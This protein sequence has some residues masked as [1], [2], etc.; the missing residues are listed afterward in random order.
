M[1]LYH[2]VHCPFC[3]RVRLALG[4]LQLAYDSNVVPY[5]DE[6]TPTKLTGKKMLPIMA[7]DDGTVMNESLDIINKLDSNNLLKNELMITHQEEINALLDRIGKPVHNLCMPYW[8]WTPEFNEQSR[9]YFQKKKEI[10]RGPFKNLIHQKEEFIAE[11]DLILAGLENDLRPFYQNNEMTILDIALAAHLWGMY[12]FPEFQFSP[13]IHQY[14][15]KI[16]RQCAFDYHA[17]FWR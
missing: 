6:E 17:D 2:Y 12:I 16:K 15:Q 3:V 13:K 8:I 14:L 4:Y 11:L 9:E 5:N 7:F 10:K 1:K